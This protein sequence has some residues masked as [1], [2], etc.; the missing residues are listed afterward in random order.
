MKYQMFAIRDGA[1]QMFHQAFYARN[2]AEAKR[3]VKQAMTESDSM[4][5]TNPED[6]GLYCVGSFDCSTGILSAP[7]QP[8]FLC[9]ANELKEASANVQ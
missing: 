1:V 6:F 8:E 3:I 9:H 4:L 7:I 5:A 2:E